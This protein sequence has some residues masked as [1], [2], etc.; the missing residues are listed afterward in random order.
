VVVERSGQ[1]KESRHCF[2]INQHQ[3]LDVG[4]CC[5]VFKAKGKKRNNATT[6]QTRGRKGRCKQ[7]TKDEQGSIQKETAT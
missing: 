2:E 3:Q 7:K 1:R 4:D 5:F 6:T